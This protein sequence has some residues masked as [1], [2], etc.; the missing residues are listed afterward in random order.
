MN[1]SDFEDDL[2]D[3]NRLF[4]RVAPDKAA[5]LAR[6]RAR[7]E[8]LMERGSLIPAEREQLTVIIERIIELQRAAQARRYNA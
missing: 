2:R 4:S 5:P 6:W 8:V 3:L 1:S 7:L